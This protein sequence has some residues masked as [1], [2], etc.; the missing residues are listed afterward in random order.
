M[1]PVALHD[2]ALIVTDRSAQLADAVISLAEEHQV[3]TLIGEPNGIARNGS[4]AHQRIFIKHG[5]N[6]FHGTEVGLLLRSARTRF[7]LLA[8]SSVSEMVL[9]A[10]DAVTRGYEAAILAEPE[11]VV[12]A[13][14]LITALF[15]S[16]QERPSVLALDELKQAWSGFPQKTRNWHGASKDEALLRSL[17][18]RLDPAHT[19]YVLVDVQNDFCNAGR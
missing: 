14:T 5:G 7:V 13:Q 16:R 6:V 3:F 18:D 11:Q 8:G 17:E 10:A 1:P 19:A 15:A 2:T 12:D 4:G 9:D